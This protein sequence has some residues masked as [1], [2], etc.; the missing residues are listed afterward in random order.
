MLTMSTTPT[1]I[2]ADE[3]TFVSDDLGEWIKVV[4]NMNVEVMLEEL[5][6]RY[7]LL[8]SGA[9]NAGELNV[10]MEKCRRDLYFIPVYTSRRLNET[11]KKYRN[12]TT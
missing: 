8:C 10:L 9:N 3:P 2:V 5:F 1:W 12:S 6:K 7:E 11:A 4:L